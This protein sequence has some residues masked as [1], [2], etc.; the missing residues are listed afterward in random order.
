VTLT[1]T[2]VEATCHRIPVPLPRL[3][4]PMER[5]F[6]MVRIET[7]EGIVGHGL[8]SGTPHMLGSIAAFINNEAGPRL[9]D[10]STSA[11][12]TERVW[13]ETM[14]KFN[15]RSLTGV[16]S[17]GMS[18]IDIALWDIKGKFFEQPVS[19]LL[20]GAFDTAQAYIT[21]GVRHYDDETLAS[22]AKELV[23]E[24]HTKLKMVV[25]ETQEGLNPFWGASRARALGSDIH[26]DARRVAAVRDAIG[27]EAEIMIDANYGLTL[28]EAKRLAR[29]V[30][31]YDVAWF[32]E[33]VLLNDP[34][35]LASL[36]QATSTPIAAGQNLG[37]SWDH[38]RLV[39]AHAVDILQL[40]VV[41]CGGYTEALKIANMA[42]AFN[43]PIA[44]GAGWP[45]HNLHLHAAV[46]N[47]GPVEYHWSAWKVG[48]MIFNDPPPP[49]NNLAKVPDLPGL[50]FD[51]KWDV[52]NEYKVD[53]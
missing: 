27:P 3:D 10:E 42:R 37:H 15:K 28:A 33:P 47:G 43:L 50:G 13:Q 12:H 34:Q 53:F 20:G 8:T 45:H 32:E 24:G 22:I 44:N 25:A 1:I 30:E 52:L 48:E 41:F 51:P 40:N 7:E 14:L 4:E 29:M 17:S 46:S 36:R 26:D 5:P 2:S 35:H 19:T 49:E 39:D 38:R 11:L 23:D 31:P 21:F 6:V 18:G 9:V 16:W